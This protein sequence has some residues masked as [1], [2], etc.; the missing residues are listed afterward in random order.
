M[1]C[2]L[3]L[4]FVIVFSLCN[5]VVVPLLLHIVAFL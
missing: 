5:V 4:G 1:A 3:V 2:N